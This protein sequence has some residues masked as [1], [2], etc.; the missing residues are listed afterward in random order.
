MPGSVSGKT[1]VYPKTS[2]PKLPLIITS[3]GTISNS[4]H[5]FILFIHS[6]HRLIPANPLDISRRSRMS[7]EFSTMPKEIREQPESGVS[8]CFSGSQDHNSH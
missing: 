8:C 5:Y 3:H 1:T 2:Y 4:F 6:F 7:A